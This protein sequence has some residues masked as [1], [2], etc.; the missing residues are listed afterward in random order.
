MSPPQNSDR[1]TSDADF[2]PDWFPRTEHTIPRRPVPGE[3]HMSEASSSQNQNH[4]ANE[5]L[6]PDRRTSAA[7]SSYRLSD[8]SHGASSSG[9]NMCAV[10]EEGGDEIPSAL[11]EDELVIERNRDRAVK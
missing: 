1:R 11:P 8:V 6:H 5:Y 4:V 10:E 7:V 9:S 2:L 3:Q